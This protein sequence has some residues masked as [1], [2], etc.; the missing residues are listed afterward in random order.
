MERSLTFSVGDSTLGQIIRGQFDTNFVA[1]DDSNEV[2][3]HAPG[4]VR[5]DFVAG[6]QL[7]SEPGVG[8][9]LSDSAFDFECFFFLSQLLSWG[10]T[11][12]ELDTASGATQTGF[13]SFLHT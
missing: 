12:A 4:D 11:F 13:L 9:G 5:H 1:R 8:E 3:A 6:F 7:D 10:L 2:F